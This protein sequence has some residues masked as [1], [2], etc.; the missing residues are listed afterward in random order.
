MK[1]LPQV[2]AGFSA[3]TLP[4]QPGVKSNPAVLTE[5]HRRRHYCHKT[6][7]AGGR[8]TAS[9]F[10][11]PA[12]H[13]PCGPGSKVT[14]RSGDHVT[15]PLIDSQMRRPVKS[16]GR[17]QPGLDP[18]SRPS[19]RR[20][21]HHPASQGVSPAVTQRPHPLIPDRTKEEDEEEEQ[22]EKEEEGEE[23]EEEKGK[24]KEEEKGGGEGQRR[25]TRQRGRRRT[26][27]RRGRRRK[28]KRRGRR[29]RGG[30]RRKRRRRKEEEEE[31]QGEEEGGGEEEEQEEGEGEEKE[32]G[33]EEDEEEEEVEEEE[34]EEEKE[35]VE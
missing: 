21:R 24:E 1:A 13:S 27:R 22:E 17:H 31:K 25:G 8:R 18:P 30:G 33:E 3:N 10:S 12:V 26:R 5:T 23:E 32:E 28:G 14:A 7:L 20:T 9:R 35:E 4:R 15:P 19:A 2:T 16:I 34:E 29:S 6:S 11:T